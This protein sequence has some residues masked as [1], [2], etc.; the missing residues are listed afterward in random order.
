M[1]PDLHPIR[2][3]NIHFLETDVL[4]WAGVQAIIVTR[5]FSQQEILKKWFN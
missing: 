5:E 4:R 2:E 1:P 3:F